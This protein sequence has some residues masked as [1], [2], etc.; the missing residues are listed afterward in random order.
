[1]KT[2]SQKVVTETDHTVLWTLF[3][4]AEV[5]VFKGRDLWQGK[6][7]MSQ[8]WCEWWPLGSIAKACKHPGLFVLHRVFPNTFFS[9]PDNKEHA[10]CLLC[11]NPL[12]REDGQ[13]MCKTGL[14]FTSSLLVLKRSVSFLYTFAH[15]L[16]AWWVFGGEGHWQSCSLLWQLTVPGDPAFISLLNLLIVDLARPAHHHP[17]VEK[18]SLGRSNEILCPLGQ[19][20]KLLHFNKIQPKTLP[21]P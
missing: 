5:M 10:F 18:R 7:V 15:T 17:D 14:L 2:S 19:H 20:G 6:L 4:V 3:K 16:L 9:L 1:M 8:H 11:S 13:K 12:K 21:W